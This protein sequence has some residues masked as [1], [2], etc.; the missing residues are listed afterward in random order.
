MATRIEPAIE[1]GKRTKG[2]SQAEKIIRILKDAGNRGVPNYEFPKQAILR[3]SAR[4]D[5]LR[6]DGYNIYCERQVINGRS[7]GV[8]MYYL[9]ESDDV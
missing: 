2:L 3:Y 5:E 4:I 9:T 8:W 1:P 7:T 6:K